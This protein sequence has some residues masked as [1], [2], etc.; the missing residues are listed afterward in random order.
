MRGFGVLAFIAVLSACA[1]ALA[2]GWTVVK[3]RGGV[4]Q[5]IEGKWIDVGRGDIIPDDRLLRTLADG[6]ADLQRAQ[7][8]LTLGADTQIQI[9]DKTEIRYTS[10]QQ[11][12]GTVEVEAQVENVPHFAVETKFL[13]AVVKGTHFVV[14]ASDLGASVAVER[15]FVA[16]ESKAS[17][18]STT[19][20]VGQ[21]ASVAPVTDLVLGG[22]GPLPA[23]FGADG[24]IVQPE[25]AAGTGQPAVFAPGNAAA[26]GP[27]L[28]LQD[29][30]ASPQGPAGGAAVTTATLIGP[31][32]AGLIPRLRGSLGGGPLPPALFE[33]AAP[34]PA[35]EQPINLTTIAIGMLLGAA[36][37]ALALLFRRYW[38]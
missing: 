1:P 8:V 13:A 38:S 25:G 33:A 17:K 10:V 29:A 5:M 36:I 6:H 24:T 11:D 31:A 23:I 37:G 28:P 30:V 18:R 32:D 35:K 34:G 9:H 4:Q 21:V 15:G 14:T 19:V 3:L 7:E 2:D 12:F 20:T 27:A 22:T 26:S 16:V